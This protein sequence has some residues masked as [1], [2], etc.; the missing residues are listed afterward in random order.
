MR[1]DKPSYRV[2][3]A[4]RRLSRD[5]WLS[6]EEA[7]DLC[8]RLSQCASPRSWPNVAKA[9]MCGECEFIGM[10]HGEPPTY[11]FDPNYGDVYRALSGVKRKKDASVELMILNFKLIG[12]K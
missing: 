4:L 1:S 10:Y 6:G 5:R 11:H 9:A 3:L 12:M 2:A 8:F 7:S